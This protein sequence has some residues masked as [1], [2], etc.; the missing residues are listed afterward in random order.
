MPVTIGTP[1][2]RRSTPFWIVPLSKQNVT[3]N[4]IEGGKLQGPI[5]I[6]NQ[7]IKWRDAA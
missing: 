7:K 6:N 4:A 1:F 2:E 5:L 3:R